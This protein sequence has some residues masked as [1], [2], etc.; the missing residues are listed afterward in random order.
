VLA[1]RAAGPSPADIVNLD[2]KAAS[3]AADAGHALVAH[4]FGVG[5]VERVAIE[6]RGQAL[7]VTHVTRH[8]GG[9]RYHEG[10]QA[11]RV[12]MMLGGVSTGASEDLERACELAIR[13]VGSLGVSKAFGLMSVLSVL[14]VQGVPRE[15]LAP[16]VPAAVLQEARALPGPGRQALPIVARGACHVGSPQG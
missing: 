2:N 15:R 7:G 6:P 10:E 9:P 16:D 8:P 1:R 5:A 14:S 12:A 4:A 11:S 3:S 13:R